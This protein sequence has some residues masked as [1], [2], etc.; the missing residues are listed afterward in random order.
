MTARTL[1]RFMD[2]LLTANADAPDLDVIRLA[3]RRLEAHA[4][5]IEQDCC[6]DAGA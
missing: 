1:R 6:E 3:I 5:M 4:E 2:D